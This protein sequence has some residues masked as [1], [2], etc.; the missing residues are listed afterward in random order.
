MTRTIAVVCTSRPSWAKLLPVCEALRDA[1]LQVDLIAAAYAT[2]HARGG[3]LDIMAADGWPPT[4]VL[5]AALDAN[6]LETSALTTGFLTIRLAGHFE[7]SKPDGVIVNHD[8]H[9]TI[10]ASIAAS[11]LN[12]PV[13]HTGGGER[14]GSIDDRVRWANTMLADWH[15][16]A[17][18]E[19]YGRIVAAGVPIDRVWV[20]GCPSMDVARLA[21]LD[22][23]VTRTE[24]DG[25]GTG[26]SVDP[27]QPFAMVLQHSNTE[28]ADTAARDLAHAIDHARAYPRIIWWPSSDTGHDEASKWLR[29]SAPAD[30]KLV[31]TLPPRRFLRLLGQASLAVGNSSALIRE[32]SYLGVKRIILG[33]RQRGRSWSENASTLYGDGYAAP[34]VAEVA[35]A[36]VGA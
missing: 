26:A 23:P 17:N 21:Q 32:G 29:E 33:D 5:H 6:T 34:R 19:A 25:Y 10:S 27:E 11:Y 20:S 18:V 36:M 8:R 24:L 13:L 7:Q 4:T 3:C 9:E 15:C 14:S 31:R 35:R 1:G 22:P 16:C 2:T 12:I 30:A 28:H